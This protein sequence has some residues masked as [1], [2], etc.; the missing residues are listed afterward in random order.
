VVSDVGAVAVGTPG[1]P[2]NERWD[3]TVRTSKE[4]GYGSE[5]VGIWALVCWIATVTK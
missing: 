4:I 5:S 3:G 2:M 1:R